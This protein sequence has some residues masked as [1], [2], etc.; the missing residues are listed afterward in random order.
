MQLCHAVCWILPIVLTVLPFTTNTYGQSDD[1]FW[2]FV[3]SRPG[4]PD[5]GIVTWDI[6]AFFFWIWMCI[7]GIVALFIAIMVRIRN[8]STFSNLAVSKSVSLLVFYPLILVVC[9]LPPTFVVIKE[10]LL[11]RLGHDRS[12]QLTALAAPPLQGFLL[13]IVFFSIN[14]FARNEWKA[15]CTGRVAE[16]DE[17]YMLYDENRSGFEGA[18]PSTTHSFPSAKSATSNKSSVFTMSEGLAEIWTSTDSSGNASR[19][20]NTLGTVGSVKM[21]DDV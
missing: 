9:W 15:L 16:V 6:F 12:L 14:G 5:W 20:R 21:H 18:R 4:S 19:I 10:T 7:L 2:C 13:S 17:S 1:G 8:I 11:H 3:S